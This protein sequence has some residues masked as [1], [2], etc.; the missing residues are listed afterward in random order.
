MP[1]VVAMLA[2]QCI[3]YNYVWVEGGAAVPLVVA[4]VVVLLPHA[5]QHARRLTRVGPHA[6]T[7]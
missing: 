2:Q 4:E 3:M 6:R 7:I 5:A 1:C